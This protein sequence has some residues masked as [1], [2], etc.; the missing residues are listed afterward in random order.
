MAWHGY[1]FKDGPAECTEK[2]H[3]KQ[4]SGWNRKE[5]TIFSHHELL[6]R[7]IIEVGMFNYIDVH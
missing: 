5:A 2:C 6:N 1:R 3:I 7:S 4:V